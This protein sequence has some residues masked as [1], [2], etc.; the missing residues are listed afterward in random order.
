MGHDKPAD[1]AQAVFEAASKAQAAGSDVQKQTINAFGISLRK[2]K[3]FDT[4]AVYY[5]KALELAPGDSRLL[6]NLARALFE[7]GDFK[8]CRASLVEALGSEPEFP[9][10]QKFLRYL[11]RHHQPLPDDD[12]PDMTRA[13]LL[14]NTV[15]AYRWRRQPPACPVE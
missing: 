8:A 15:E 12:F 10:A 6:F 2:R 14:V 9:E 4:A 5:R 1:A 13:I 3:D 7:K 11:E